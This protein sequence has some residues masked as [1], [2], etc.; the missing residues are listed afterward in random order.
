MAL[1][2]MEQ[3]P[4]EVKENLRNHSELVNAPRF[5]SR[6]NYAFGALQT[7]LAPPSRWESGE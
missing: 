2:T 7:N 6:D 5:G 4:E 1:A 3:A